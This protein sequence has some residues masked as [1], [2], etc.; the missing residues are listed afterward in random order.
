VIDSTDS[1][2]RSRNRRVTIAEAARILGVS[3][4]TVRRRIHAGRIEAIREVRPQGSAWCVLLPVSPGVESTRGGHTAPRVESDQGPEC[5]TD[6]TP[7]ETTSAVSTAALVE[8][9]AR[10][11]AELVEVRT[12]SDRRADQLL[13]QADQLVAQAETIG[14]LR[15]RAAVLE[16]ENCALLT[17]TATQGRESSGPS[18]RWWWCSLWLYGGVV[19]AV[20][21][22]IGLVAL[23]M[24]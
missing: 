24:H 2:R 12:I 14:E 21:V 15:A 6:T 9:I 20:L 4:E 19:I 17:S 18:S 22:V 3:G 5:S 8:S 7:V 13:I 1:T 10:L 23:L 11:I 16:A